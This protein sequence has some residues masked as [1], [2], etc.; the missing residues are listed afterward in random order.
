MEMT[1]RTR[2]VDP[3]RTADGKTR[4]Q[5]DPVRLETLWFNTGTLCNLTCENCYIESSPSNDRLVY[6]AAD[7]V[8]RYLDEIETGGMGTRE[9]G[10]TGGEP[11]M[12][13]DLLMMLSDALERGFSCL[14]LTNAMRPMM[15]C[16]DELLALKETYGKRLEIRVSVDHYSPE[17]HELERGPRSW[18]PMLLGLK[19]LS[20]QGFHLSA[21]GRTYWGES[22]AELR[23]G[24][25]A[26]FEREDI[27]I[28]PDN[29]ARL[30][31]FP[32]MDEEAEVPEITTD[33]WR[34]L[35]RSPDEMMC[36]TSRMVIKRKGAPNP[37]VVACT[38]LPY[39]PRFELGETLTEAWRAVKLNH[40]H[41]AK[42]CVLG[43]GSCSIDD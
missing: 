28:D 30:V 16:G 39:D 19:W 37:V 8:A 2:F 32:E 38:L 36:A 11:F 40:P 43:G 6:L 21:A 14:V 4:A 10:F 13:P 22:E 9:I 25:A 35:G 29:P 17:Q 24:Y 3:D 34:I 33:C 5:V 15:K 1:V 18:K 31:L 27:A 7:E 23:A 12:N 41:C 20:E 42:F 26:L